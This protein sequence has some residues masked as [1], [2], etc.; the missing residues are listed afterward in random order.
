MIFAPEGLPR[1]RTIEAELGSVDRENAE[2][3][4]AIDVLRARVHKLREDPATAERLARDELGLV[5]ETEIV[6]QF[7]K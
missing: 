3:R 6:F 4:R 1:L 2:L 5:R 7:Q